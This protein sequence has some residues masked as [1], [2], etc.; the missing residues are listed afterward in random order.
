MADRTSASVFCAV[1]KLLASDPTPQH[2]AFARTL[3]GHTYAYDF[4][5]YQLECDE[6]LI[7]LGLARMGVDPEYPGDS[8]VMLYGP[9]DPD[10]A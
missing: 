2:V 5:S 8:P 9:E 3:W 6:A 10:H 4:S 1:F 7:A